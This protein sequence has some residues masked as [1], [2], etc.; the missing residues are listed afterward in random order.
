MIKIKK[1]SITVGIPF[2]NKTNVEYLDI[3]IMSVINQTAPADKIHLIQ[4]G[5][6][7]SDLLNLINNYIKKYNFIEHLSLPKKG[8]PHALN[9]SIKK[10]CTEFYARMDA[11]DICIQN[12]FEEQLNY[13]NDNPKVEILGSWAY[14]FECDHLN[15]SLYLN[16]TP[17]DK[18][19]IEN[20]FHYRNP[21]I[22]PSIMF[23][24]KVFDKIG[25]YNEK[26]L[27]DQ[28]LELWSRALRFN[29][30]IYNIQKPLLYL[31]TEDRLKRRS[32]LSAIWRQIKIR[33]SYNTCSFKLNFLKLAAILLRI[34][35][36]FIS[37][38]CYKNLRNL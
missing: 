7:G 38:W 20:Y 27:T 1:N 9:Q 31:R 14:E 19:N 4:D 33:Y 29:I 10:T 17:K 6:I 13:L 12:R 37:D 15:E 25:F 18:K 16:K 2:Y 22:H 35:P 8:L 3:A 28:D 5:N 21:L 32:H 30:K 26:F 24:K 34:L 23:R 36:I 11:D